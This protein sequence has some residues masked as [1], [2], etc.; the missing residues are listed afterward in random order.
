MASAKEYPPVIPFCAIMFRDKDLY[1]KAL[2]FLKT[3]IGETAKILEDIDFSKE[4][5]YYDGEMGGNIKKTYVVFKNP[6]KREFLPQLKIKTNGFEQEF[7]KEGKRQ[8][9]LDPGYITKDKFVLAS[10]KD[11]F[12]RIS[13]GDGIFAEVTVHFAA[14]DKIRRFSWTYADYLLEPVRELLV[15]GRRLANKL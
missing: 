2:S 8:I 6:M 14:N 13:I 7:A 15:F 10:A 9:N 4:T 1:E 11:Y 5:D 3:Q 12:H